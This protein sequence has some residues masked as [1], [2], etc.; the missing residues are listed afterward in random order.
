MVGDLT[1]KDMTRELELEATV[2]G[3]SYGARFWGQ[4][5]GFSGRLRVR[6]GRGAASRETCR[7]AGKAL[8]QAPSRDHIAARRILHGKEAVPGSS[9]GEGLN[10]CK[11][12]ILSDYRAPLDQ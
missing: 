9:P 10:T 11:S 6:Q 8:Y 3:V 4:V 7:T 1:I 12:A 5:R 2:Q